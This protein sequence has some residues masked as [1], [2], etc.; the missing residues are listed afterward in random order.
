[1]KDIF[2]YGNVRGARAAGRA[3]VVAMAALAAVPGAG[4]A[5]AWKPDRAVE[6]IIPTA[7]GGGVDRSART[8]QRIFQEHNLLGVPVTLVNKPGGGGAVS[9]AY[10]NNH[11][12][13]GHYI[14]INTPNIIANDINA[15]STVR[16]TEVT[17]LATL[18][19]EPTVIAVR[20]DGPILTGRDF[21]DRL[22]KDPG[23]LA[24]STPTT[25]GS[26][27]HMAFALV[28]KAAGVDVKKIKPV[29]LGSGGEGALAVLGGHIDAHSGTPSSVL[30]LV[31]TGKLRVIGILA[32]KR[33]TGAYANTPTWT[34]QGFP[35]VMD[36]WRG[37]I[38]PRGFT[39]EQ[40]AF[41]E[42]ALAKAVQTD[43]WK[44]ELARNIWEANFL[45]SAQT[46]ALFDADYA[47]YRAI[48]TELGLRK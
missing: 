8:L 17:P 21:V 44:Q 7:P 45:R 9:L 36:T 47:E 16:Y 26:I 13:D 11:A 31:E 29:I 12:G 22:R 41:W 46:R 28:A 48:L 5:A 25:L 14:S 27:N 43:T 34:E 40:I 18:F 37:V 10:M 33:L 35:A 20:A 23:S 24:V 3:V 38:A 19:S 15:R 1:M 32:P 39:P 4:A 2:N 30:R 42:D 6:I